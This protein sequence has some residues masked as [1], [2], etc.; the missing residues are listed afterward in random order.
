LAI[1]L[2]HGDALRRAGQR[3]EARAVLRNALELAE[4]AGAELLATRARDALI[5]ARDRID[6]PASRGVA[7]LTVSER[8]ALPVRAAAVLAA[9]LAAAVPAAA[10]AHEG[11]AMAPDSKLVSAGDRYALVD[12]G[13][14][15]GD[16]CEP[17]VHISR[18]LAHGVAVGTA[19]IDADGWLTFSRKIPRTTARGSRLR[20][21]ATQYCDGIGETRP[22]TVRVGRPEHGC[23][24]FIT[25]DETAYVLRVTAGMSCTRGVRAVG[26]FIDTD[27]EPL[28]LM[29]AWADPSIAGHDAACL[30]AGNP[31][32]RVTARR[33]RE[34]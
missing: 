19:P 8:L 20:F 7:A 1:L 14:S 12:D 17:R 21:E 33:I 2:E 26:P 28:G 29:C 9:A 31:A 15:L 6:R 30:R 22:A 3:A 10:S 5:A 13:W 25:A 34:V 32:S 16:G 23:P 27:I 11:P 18:V 24:G 4:E